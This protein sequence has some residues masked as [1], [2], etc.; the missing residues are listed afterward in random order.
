MESATLRYF[1]P[2]CSYSVVGKGCKL[3]STT[4]PGLADSKA[5][6]S[7]KFT[8]GEVYNTTKDM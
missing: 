6:Q 2:I 4:G 5:A 1:L 7:I 8:S 3:C